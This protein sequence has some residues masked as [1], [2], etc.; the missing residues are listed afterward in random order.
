MAAAEANGSTPRRFRGVSGYLPVSFL[1]ANFF[2][3]KASSPEPAAPAPLGSGFC[4]DVSGC[5][6]LMLIR[7]G[8]T[9]A[10][11]EADFVRS[12]PCGEKDSQCGSGTGSID[13]PCSDEF[14]NPLSCPVFYIT[15]CGTPDIQ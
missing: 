11:G 8:Y 9:C 14:G 12:A 6:N 13:R 10:C 5:N 7:N 2:P 4:C 1:P 3:D 15:A